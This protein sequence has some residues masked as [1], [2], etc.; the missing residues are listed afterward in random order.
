MRRVCLLFMFCFP[1]ATH[2]SS[3]GKLTPEQAFDLFALAL[4]ESDAQAGETLSRAMRAAKHSDAPIAIKAARLVPEMV[5]ALAKGEIED[6]VP[7]EFAEQL[8]EVLRSTYLRSRCRAIS[9]VPMGHTNQAVQKVQL[10]F[11]CQV[12]DWS[13]ATPPLTGE[14]ISRMMADSSFAYRLITT[15]VPGLPRRTITDTV[16]LTAD[17]DGNY[18]FVDVQALLGPLIQ[19]TMPMVMLGG[20]DRPQLQP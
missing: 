7:A 20:H 19:S 6:D 8:G 18:F 13:A 1:I 16:A 9:S 12:P 14:V 5:D 2:A 17:A 4:L 11:S 3:S 15:T 10:S